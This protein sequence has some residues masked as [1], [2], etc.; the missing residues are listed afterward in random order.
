[1]L[2]E[3]GLKTFHDF[4]VI[5]L[6]DLFSVLVKGDIVGCNEERGT[7]IQCLHV[8]LFGPEAIRE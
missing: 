7:S 8:G 6:G 1:M 3:D 4:R 5:G 2:V